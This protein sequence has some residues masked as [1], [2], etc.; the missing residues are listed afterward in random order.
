ME[1]AELRDR[2]R[3]SLVAAQTETLIFEILLRMA[4]LH[5]QEAVIVVGADSASA[6]LRK[7]KSLGD[8]CAGFHGMPAIAVTMRDFATRAGDALQLRNRV[9]H[10]H[11]VDWGEGWGGLSVTSPK[12]H[13]YRRGGGH[14]QVVSA[15]SAFEQALG[16]GE[17]AFWVAQEVQRVRDAHTANFDRLA[18]GEMPEDA[19]LSDYSPRPIH[20][21][22]AEP[23]VFP[24]G[25]TDE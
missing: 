10:E 17:R 5:P 16:Q 13:G 25:G 9:M 1:D 23:D 18:S 4:G 7:L 15:L 14:E 22:W 11:V 12:I 3:L 6:M 2:G 8:L 21:P 19:D 20:I 24:E